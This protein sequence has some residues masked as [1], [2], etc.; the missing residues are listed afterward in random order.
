MVLDW[1]EKARREVLICEGAMGTALQ[2]MGLP[3][4]ALPERWNSDRP[5]AVESVH[6][7]YVEAGADLI[8]TNTFGANRFRLERHG[9]AEMVEELN[10]AAVRI[11]R[12][13]AGEKAVVL[14]DVGP[15]G[16]LLRPY[17]DLEAE[18]AQEAFTEQIGALVA[19][20][21][22]GLILETFV[23]LEEAVAALRAAKEV[24]SLPV[25]CTMAFDKG[26]RTVMGVSGDQ[27]IGVLLEEGA[28]VAGAN[29]GSG[30]EDMLLAIGQMR[31]ADGRA[32][33]IAQPNAGAPKLIGERTVFDATPEEMAEWAVRF[34]EAGVNIV[35]SCCGSNHLHTAAIA[36]AVRSRG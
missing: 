21:V 25:I 16:R 17:G 14:G 28:D 27:A 8:Q 15:T 7:A 1:V 24:A 23:A 6:R 9:L 26:G 19:A 29:C 18:G 22:D 5:E 30:P 36:K 11:A 31:Q 34:V 2:S 13:A 32:V 12:R 20:G 33:L 35:G 4:G 10:R 3:I